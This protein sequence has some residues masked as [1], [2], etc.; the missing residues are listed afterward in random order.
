MLASISQGSPEA[1]AILSVCFLLVL[2]FE[3]SNGFHDTANAVATVIYTNALKPT[4]AVIWSGL[5]N[6][7]GVLVGGIAVAYALVELI[8]AEVLSPPDGGTAAGMLAALFTSAL[9]WNVGTWWL[10]LPNSSSHALIGSL[11]GIAIETA[12][13]HGRGLRDGV[14]WQQVWNV[15]ASLLFSPLLGFALAFFLFKLLSAFIHDR[16]LYEPP[17]G[18]KPPIWWMRYLLILTCTGVSFAHGTNDGQK[19]IGLIMLTIIGLMPANYALNMQISSQQIAGVA[20]TMPV[21]AN[22]IERFGGDQK[23][24]GADSAR[25]LGERFSHIKA[26]ADIPASERSAIRDDLNHVLEQLKTVGEA[27]DISDGDKK[28]AKSIHDNLM[29]S[30]E[31]APWWVRVLSALCLG[32]GTMVGYKRIVTTLGE[33]LGNKHL[34]PAQGASAELVAA[35]LIGF[36]GFSGYPVSTTHVVTGGIAGTMVASGAGVQGRTVWQIAV[37]W[38]LTLP[39]TIVI[40]GTLFYLLS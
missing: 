14:D 4:Y 23:Q 15:L 9:L 34:V 39:A 32:I 1:L 6:F 12:L 18:D 5:M 8:P 28:Q 13:T 11:I 16:H 26:A 30:V 38:L 19:S 33:R 36:A 7:L 37:A 2:V 21:V 20:G 40:S 3:F 24:Q 22:L 29:K 35:G 10:G 25:S 17:E 27:K 31:Y